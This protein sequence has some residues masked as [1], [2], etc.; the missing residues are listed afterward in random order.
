VGLDLP[1][2]AMTAY[3]GQQFDAQVPLRGAVEIRAKLAFS[4]KLERFWIRQVQPWLIR[5]FAQELGEE[6]RT[7]ATCDAFSQAPAGRRR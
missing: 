4:S 7:G 2:H 3:Q 6:P 1:Q 5:W